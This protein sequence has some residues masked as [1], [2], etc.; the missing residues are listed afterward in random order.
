MPSNQSLIQAMR[1]R[2]ARGVPGEP[3]GSL[4][5][6]APG[7]VTT[8]AGPRAASRSPLTDLF[9]TFE[10]AHAYFT[11]ISIA[12]SFDPGT[13]PA[14]FGLRRLRPG[15]DFGDEFSL[16]SLEGAALP[17]DTG[18]NGIPTGTFEAYAWCQSD[19]TARGAALVVGINLPM[20]P[21]A[22][23][24]W[25]GCPIPGVHAGET[26]LRSPQS[27]SSVLW[28]GHLPPGALDPLATIPSRTFARSWA[29]FV[30]RVSMGQTLDVGL[31]VAGAEVPWA[32]T[33]GVIVGY[34]ALQL[35]L[36]MSTNRQRWGE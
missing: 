15:V 13:D 7:V 18:G 20:E 6:P 10:T 23:S 27:Q 9:P 21:G 35:G 26:A 33:N 34:G 8:P 17:P 29:P 4:A 22:W 36:G 5:L 19:P 25:P 11:E 1:N 12:G 32:T 30:K 3:A 14:I 31:V 24:A 16:F 2:P 28:F